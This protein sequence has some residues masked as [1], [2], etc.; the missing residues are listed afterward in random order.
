LLGRKLVV[1]FS[2]HKLSEKVTDW[3]EKMG[4]MGNIRFCQV[5]MN[6]SIGLAKKLGFVEKTKI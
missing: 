4:F 6:L 5:N 2:W 1:N 3:R